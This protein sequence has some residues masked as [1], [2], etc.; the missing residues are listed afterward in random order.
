LDKIKKSAYRELNVPEWFG[1]IIRYLFLLGRRNFNSLYANEERQ[2]NAILG[3]FFK[4]FS[5]ALLVYLA[6]KFDF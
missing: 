6:I 1:A 2:K 3:T 4:I 5:V